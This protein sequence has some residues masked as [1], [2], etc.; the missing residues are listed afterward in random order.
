MELVH[1][2]VVP[3][4]V[5]AELTRSLL[6]TEGIESMQRKTNF[7]A[8]ASDGAYGGQHEILVKASDLET[9]RALIGEAK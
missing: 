3:N 7:G 1:L 6:R 4:P 5:E 9:A 8:G 2:T